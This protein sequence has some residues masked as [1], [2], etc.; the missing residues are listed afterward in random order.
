MAGTFESYVAAVAATPSLVELVAGPSVAEARGFR[1]LGEPQIEDRLSRLEEQVAVRETYEGEDQTDELLQSSVL[2]AAGATD[3]RDALTLLL[4]AEASE[5]PDLVE[6]TSTRRAFVSG[7]MTQMLE[8]L[9]SAAEVPP[10]PAADRPE[11]WA[12]FEES[13]RKHAEQIVTTGADAVKSLRSAISWGEI[14]KFMDSALDNNDAY[15]A[16]K[17]MIGRIRAIALRLIKS[18]IDKLTKAI[19]SDRVTT[20]INTKREQFKSWI[21]GSATSDALSHV[22]RAEGVVA[23]CV[24]VAKERNADAMRQAAAIAAA[25]AVASHATGM[26]GFLKD[27]LATFELVQGAFAAFGTVLV[28]SP[29]APYIGAAFVL[30]GLAIVW[31]VQDH[32]DSPSRSP[33]RTP[34]VA[35]VERSTKFLPP[36]RPGVRTRLGPTHLDRQA[37]WSWMSYG[38]VLR[39]H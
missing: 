38:E 21:D 34:P 1:P 25:A 18:A 29:A 13:I 4:A 20:F 17:E 39:R 35:Y 36:H 28:T 5:R 26:A 8:D 16:A 6:P 15:M 32:L 37:R 31:Q 2:S 23:D 10:A 27:V 7:D 11:D 22:F 30:V 12:S 19:G 33:F 24:T 3:L 9:R 14:G